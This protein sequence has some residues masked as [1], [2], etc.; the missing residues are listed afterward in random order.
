MELHEPFTLR[1]V[2]ISRVQVCRAAFMHSTPVPVHHQP[3]RPPY[4]WYPEKGNAFLHLC[5]LSP[6]QF[7]EAAPLKCHAYFQV[8]S[9]FPRTRAP[10]LGA[11]YLFGSFVEFDRLQQCGFCPQQCG[12]CPHPVAHAVTSASIVSPGER[13]S[14]EW[15]NSY[16]NVCGK[17]GENL[18]GFVRV[19]G[20]IVIVIIIIIHIFMA[21]A[22]H[23]RK[24][25]EKYLL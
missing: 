14:G 11:I 1:E 25:L 13:E 23:I 10:L 15:F 9:P 6:Y 24:G 22:W 16:W 20:I 5:L 4:L 8:R 2:V 17:T 19:I 18:F 12:F 21:L 3:S 7:P